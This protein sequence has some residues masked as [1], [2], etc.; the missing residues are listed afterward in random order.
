[1]FQVTLLIKSYNRKNEYH[2][3]L[4]LFLLLK[5][6][7]LLLKSHIKMPVITWIKPQHL[8]ISRLTHALLYT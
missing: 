7:F 4:D 5:A 6:D 2:G 3:L 1:M 8:T